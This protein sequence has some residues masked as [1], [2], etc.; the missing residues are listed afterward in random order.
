MNNR[1]LIVRCFPA[2]DRFLITFQQ[3]R[4]RRETASIEL[5]SKL[6]DAIR[7]ATNEQVRADEM[8]SR[9]RDLIDVC[10]H[11]SKKIIRLQRQC[12]EQAETIASM[13]NETVKPKR[14]KAALKP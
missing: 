13:C 14:R 11:K 5:I 1:Q 4:K 8:E 2:I 12:A 3:W 10:A 9:L 6:N 7:R